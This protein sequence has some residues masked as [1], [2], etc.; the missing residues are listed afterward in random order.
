MANINGNEIFFGIIGS[1]GSGATIGE[2]IA[3]QAGFYG[4]T[5]G[6]ATYINE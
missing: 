1:V 2:M 6:Q 4:S 3:I 5:T